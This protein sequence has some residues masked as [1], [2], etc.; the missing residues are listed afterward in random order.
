[1]STCSVVWIAVCIQIIVLCYFLVSR[2]VCP[3]ALVCACA[4]VRVCVCVREREFLHCCSL[5]WASSIKWFLLSKELS[6]KKNLLG[7]KETDNWK[8]EAGYTA[9]SKDNVSFLIVLQ[10]A[11]VITFKNNPFYVLNHVTVILDA[12]DYQ[13]Y[14]Y[15]VVITFNGS[16][17]YMA[18]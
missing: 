6:G 18:I 7:R 3:C 5:C 1:M 8:D 11:K 9:N 10:N 4:C 16:F 15:R 2:I 17:V 13:I 12:R 14:S